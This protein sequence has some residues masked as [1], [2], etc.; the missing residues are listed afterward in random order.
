M[1]LSSVKL[2]LKC[3]DSVSAH[4][5]TPEHAPQ[6]GSPLRVLDDVV[7]QEAGQALRLLGAVDMPMGSPLTLQTSECSHKHAQ[8][9]SRH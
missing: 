7:E 2:Q 1:S 9:G 6:H 5:K 3:K 8:E 4:G